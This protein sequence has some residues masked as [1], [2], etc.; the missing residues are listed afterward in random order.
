MGK[1]KI[2][3]NY[4]EYN[5]KIR[6]LIGAGYNGMKDIE[7]LM[8]LGVNMVTYGVMP[9][10][11][12]K[13]PYVGG[14]GATVDNNWNGFSPEYW[15]GFE[16]QIK[17]CQKLEIVFFAII[18]STCLRKSGKGT[19]SNHLWNVENGGPINAKNG[20]SP[21]RTLGSNKILYDIRPYNTLETWQG[22][23]QWR[24]EQLI[25]KAMLILDK[26][27]NTGVIL[28]W[29]TYDQF[30]ARWSSHMVEYMRS[31]SKIPIGM[32]TWLKDQIA[33]VKARSG[34]DVFGFMEGAVVSYPMH[35]GDKRADLLDLDEYVV[36]SNG[37]Q[38]QLPDSRYSAKHKQRK[39]KFFLPGMEK[40]NIINICTHI[41]DSLRMGANVSLPFPFWWQDVNTEYVKRDCA[42]KYP[43]IENYD[44][45]LVN[46]EVTKFMKALKKEMKKIDWT[47]EPGDKVTF[48][49][50]EWLLPTL[51]EPKPK[52]PPPKDEEKDK[53]EKIETAPFETL[54]P[55]IKEKKMN[56]E[57]STLEYWRH[58]ARTWPA[59]WWHKL[60]ALP[61][62]LLLAIL[63]QFAGAPWWA[64][65]IAWLILAFIDGTVERRKRKEDR[66]KY[67]SLTAESDEGEILEPYAKTPRCPDE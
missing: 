51:P 16:N 39:C 67:R 54:E 49:W 65:P 64:M 42:E 29:E 1:L 34:V 56:K 53:E 45:R 57:M 13:S 59:R 4:F 9:S 27:P 28:E 38:A 61:V 66:V 12:K 63:I 40:E 18:F 10:G 6:P 5:G 47:K 55:E 21:F 62:T 44:I 25:R 52:E 26:Y 35:H 23:S 2:S 3:G 8:K 43:E 36:V 17:E 46:K 32:G 58:L 60:I 37:W 11:G 48:S 31:I 14:A 41:L 22:K 19:W 20:V 50:C 24:Q 30:S 7:K 15:K 33:Q